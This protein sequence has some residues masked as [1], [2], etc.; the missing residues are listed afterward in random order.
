M[1]LGYDC[2]AQQHRL[3]EWRLLKNRKKSSEREF[4]RH[5]NIIEISI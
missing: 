4:I 1:Y 3:S 5:R 2:L